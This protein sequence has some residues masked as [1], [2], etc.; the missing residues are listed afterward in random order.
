[1]IAT[2]Y[3]LYQKG[4]LAGDKVEAAIKRLGVDP[5]KSFPFY[6]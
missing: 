2:L 5:E 1:V 3:S 6:L 4:S